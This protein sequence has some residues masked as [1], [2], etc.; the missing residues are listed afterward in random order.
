MSKGARLGFRDGVALPSHAASLTHVG[1]K[2]VYVLGGYE[3]ETNLDNRTPDWEPDD[4]YED[5]DAASVAAMS[6]LEGYP[7]GFVSVIELRGSNGAVVLDVSHRGSEK[8]IPDWSHA[9][10]GQGTK[11]YEKT[12]GVFL[13]SA[14]FVGLGLWMALFPDQGADSR[15]SVGF[16]RLIGVV[17][18]G[19]FGF[20]ILV[21][22]Y[23]WLRGLPISK[24]PQT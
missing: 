18:V 15:N 19:F 23:R 13:T 12:P 1:F 21:F 9:K 16:V 20:G 3:D 8:I 14:M 5:V 7:K 10:R 2:T 17:T 11:W 6:W 4:S 22:I 24:R